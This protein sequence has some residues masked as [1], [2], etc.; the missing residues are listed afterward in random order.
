MSDDAQALLVIATA[1]THGASARVAEVAFAH[2]LPGWAA[3]G[4]VGLS[5]DTSMMARQGADYVN[6][7]NEGSQAG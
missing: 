6:K 4:S 5:P 1:F 2:H 3:G 7:I